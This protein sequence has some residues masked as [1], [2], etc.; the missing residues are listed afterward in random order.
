MKFEKS[1]FHI[2]FGTKLLFDGVF[3]KMK[4]VRALKL[5]L[6]LDLKVCHLFWQSLF[7]LIHL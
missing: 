1:R 4:D 3:F 6:E 7:L 2:D 5:N